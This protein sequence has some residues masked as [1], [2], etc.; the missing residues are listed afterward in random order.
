MRIPQILPPGEHDDFHDSSLI[1][2]QLHPS[3]TELRVVL[4]TPNAQGREELWMIT[5]GGLLRLEFETVGRGT[6]A[7]M[8]PVEI[9]SVYSDSRSDELLRWRARLAAL[10]SGARES[11]EVHHVVLASSFQRGWGE[12]SGLE[13]IQIICRQFRIEPAPR[14]YRGSEYSRPRIE[15]G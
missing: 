12:R 13:G 11:P 15:G 2:V 7:A 4:S 5:F 8:T 3:L 9:Y 1:D 14:D 10:A 6:G